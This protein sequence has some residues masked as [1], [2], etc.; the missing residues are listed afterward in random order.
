MK[1]RLFYIIVMLALIALPL[2]SQDN[3][4]LRHFSVSAGLGTTGI[5]A[6]A[7]TMLTDYVGFRGGIDFMPKF[8]HSTHLMLTQVNQ[9]KDVDVSKFPASSRR[10]E[11]QG[12]FH[13][14]TG[15]ALLD[16][17]P[18]RNYDFHVSIGA[19]FSGSDKI[20]TV[21]NT[22]SDLLKA[23]A[24]L[25]ARRGI[26]ADVPLSYGQVAARMGKYNI[27]P[28]D[29]GNANA[30]IKVKK[31]RPYVGIGLGQ[32]VPKKSSLNC[33]VDLGVQFSGKPHV[34]NG[35]NGEELTAEGAQG[36][37][38]GYLKTIS[39]ISFLPVLSVRLVGKIL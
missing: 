21:V 1:T 28:D 4:V 34:Y 18:S 37:D 6:D 31:V 3:N 29:D 30:Y 38:G 24:D 19:Y 12:T 14:S 36:E 20:V 39:K 11:V 7:G 8:K 22:E 32:T 13:N 35:V 26:Y 23:V 16:I 33:L 25:N 2:R 17:Y 15:H 10:V 27:M 9:T 5:I